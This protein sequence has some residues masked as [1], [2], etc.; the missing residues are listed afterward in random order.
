MLRERRQQISGVV[1]EPVDVPWRDPSYWGDLSGR[2]SRRCLDGSVQ[3]YH[4]RDS[5]GNHR[6][7][8]VRRESSARRFATPLPGE[9]AAVA[10]LNRFSQPGKLC[11]GEGIHSHHCRR[12][13][14]LQTAS[15]SSADSMPVCPSTP[16][17][18]T[19]TGRSSG[20]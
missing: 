4:R 11:T 17:A 7:A 16:P 20:R 18:R 5:Q 1:D 15:I 9:D 10:H 14:C 8:R 3:V 2:F 13:I 6:Y 19:Q 12:W